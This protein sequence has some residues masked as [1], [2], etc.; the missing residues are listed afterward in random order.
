MATAITGTS[1]ETLTLTLMNFNN[2]AGVSTSKTI[3]PTTVTVG[4][5][6]SFTNNGTF[7]PAT[8]IVSGAASFTNNDSLT[9]TTLTVNGGGAFTNSA[10]GTVTVAGTTSV[11]S[12]GTAVNHGTMTANGLISGAGTLTNRANAVLN[13]G[14]TA[15]N[16]PTITNLDLTTHTP[17]TVSYTGGAAQSIRAGAYSNL[18]LAN[19][20]I[21]TAL[22]ALTVSGTFTLSGTAAFTTG[23][24]THHFAGS[25]VHDSAVATPLVA[26]GSTINFNAPSPAAATSISGGGAATLAF[27]AVNV[28][29]T[30]GLTV[31]KTITSTGPLTVNGLLTNGAAGS[32]TLLGAGGLT[33]ANDATLANA[34][35]IDLAAGGTVIIGPSATAAL[36][37]TGTLTVGGL[38][39]GQG[40]FTNGVGGTLNYQNATAPTVA[41]MDFT[42]HATNTVNYSLAGAQTLRAGGYRNLSLATSGTKTAAGALNVSGIMTM[43][44][45][46]GFAPLGFTHTFG[47]NWV[48][49]LT[50]SVTPGG[51]LIFTGANAQ[52]SGGGTLAVAEA[53]I[54]SG[55][56]VESFIAM[57]ATTLM[58]VETG[59]A[60]TMN[61]T[62]SGTGAFTVETGATLGIRSA[63]GIS[64]A[65]ASGNVQTSGLR[66]FSPDATYRY[67][68]N[69]GNPQVTGSG[70]PATVRGLVIDNPQGVTLTSVVSVS[71]DLTLSA[72]SLSN[73]GATVTVTVL[74][75]V[76]GTAEVGETLTTTDGTWAGAP[77]FG[78]QWQRCA[79]VCVDI[80]GAT[81]DSYLVDAADDGARLRVLVTATD[82]GSLTVSSVRTD[83]V[84][85]AAPPPSPP[86]GGGGGGG[87]VASVAPVPVP[88]PGI[89]VIAFEPS[90]AVSEELS[91]T[92]PT[93]ATSTSGS[94]SVTVEV[95]AGVLS[96]GAQLRLGFLAD[97]DELLVVAPPPP[98]ARIIAGFAAQAVTSE[99]VAITQDFAAPVTIDLTVP[100]SALPSGVTDGELVLAFWNGSTWVATPATITRN[101]DGSA[102][103]RAE[104]LH[105]TVFGLFRQPVPAWYGILPRAA[106][107]FAIWRG[108]TGT[109]STAA[110][111][112]ATPKG[113]GMWRLNVATQRYESWVASSP[114]FA[115]DLKSLISGDVL[116]LRTQAST[117]RPTTNPPAATS[118][119]RPS[120]TTTQQAAPVTNTVTSTDTLTAIG[121]HFGVD[122][123]QIAAANGIA[124]PDYFIHPGQVL[125]IPRTSPTPVASNTSRTHVVSGSDTLIDL[126]SR[127]GIDWLQIAAANGIAGPNY[128]IHPGQ[129]LAIPTPRRTV[130]TG[131]AE[132]THIVGA[133][134]TLSTIAER[135]DI[136]WAVIAE[137]N[138]L[139]PPLYIVRSGQVLRIP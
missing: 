102:L 134:D 25:W 6:A 17:N 10:T 64:A 9:A 42:T 133:G 132:R 76:S 44:G 22:G 23:A 58:V 109:E 100:A 46:V 14:M 104:V 139:T 119:P 2:V 107:S 130:V 123:L 11:G 91:L 50:T 124:G 138:D 45:T 12:T 125:T 19:A 30:S 75:V 88:E 8:L 111:T 99:G 51:V 68:N 114:A 20:G 113:L 61:G 126:G 60:F 62:V 85:G 84:G 24:F 66:T 49:G 71:E 36:T 13:F 116:F 90:T 54:A 120:P 108:F 53:R 129:V 4:G 74:P 18:E 89:G 86:P 55:A 3:N 96:D 63:A 103:V 77:A 37:N 118:T 16:V 94:A 52:I 7:S 137:A 35:V 26:T 21:K 59:S 65:G 41:T 83:V 79:P 97:V 33:V 73:P 98:G 28:N 128:F 106:V 39:D 29:T 136:P 27:A 70:L 5:G 115:N 82:G 95:P 110:A 34:G 57:S 1:V 78:Y 121:V 40:T 69:S 93:V 15:A 81:A 80:D 127:Y 105:F 117:P 47:G 122:W 32:I 72:G 56:I 87:S 131:T 31:N 38:V 43:S 67:N 112:L 101:A 92:G 135:Y 48:N